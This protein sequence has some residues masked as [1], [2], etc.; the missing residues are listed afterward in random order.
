MRISEVRLITRQYGSLPQMYYTRMQSD[1]E[2]WE[3]G[4]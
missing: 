1:P 3:G 4:F 2:N